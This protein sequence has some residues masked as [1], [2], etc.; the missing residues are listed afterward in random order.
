MHQNNTDVSL[1]TMSMSSDWTIK[2]M[3]HVLDDAV[4]ELVEPIGIEPMTS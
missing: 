4:V 3:D 2:H 1:Y